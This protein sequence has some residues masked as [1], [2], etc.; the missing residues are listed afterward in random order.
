MRGGVASALHVRGIRVPA[1][2]LAASGRLART[3]GSTRGFSASLRTWIDPSRFAAE[4]RLGSDQY[5]EAFSQVRD[6]GCG[7]V[8]AGVVEAQI[9]EKSLPHR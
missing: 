6:A 2:A 9:G 5:F 8:P 4:A 7:E 1:G 3:F